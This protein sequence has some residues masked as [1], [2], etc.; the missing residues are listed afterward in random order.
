MKIERF[1]EILSFQSSSSSVSS[2]AISCKL[3]VERASR[4]SIS[5]LR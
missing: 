3:S 4:R 1:V 5:S 2:S